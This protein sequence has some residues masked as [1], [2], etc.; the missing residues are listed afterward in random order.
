MENP[1]IITKNLSKVYRNGGEIYA[2]RDV[3]IEIEKGEF[4]SIVGHSGCGKTTLLSLIGGLT[5]P[6]YGSVLIDGVDMWS[7]NDEQ[8]SEVRN[9]KIGFIFQFASLI[10]T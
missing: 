5:A 4:V 6:T 8:L 9:Q 7:L 2:V 3:N 10:P 1:A